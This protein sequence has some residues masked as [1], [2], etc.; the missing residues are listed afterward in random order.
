[1]DIQVMMDSFHLAWRNCSNNAEFKL[2]KSEHSMEEACAALCHFNHQIL[3]NGLHEW[4]EV[5]GA[6]EGPL[7]ISLIKRGEALKVPGFEVLVK[8]FGALLDTDFEKEMSRTDTEDCLNC[9]GKGEVANDLEDFDE[10]DAM[11]DCGECNGSGQIC[12]EPIM[13]LNEIECLDS[14]ESMIIPM[15]HSTDDSVGWIYAFMDRWD[16]VVDVLETEV[17]TKIETEKSPAKPL[18]KLVGSDGN[19]FAVIGVAARALRREG[20]RDQETEMRERVEKSQS[21]HQA[22][23]IIMEYVDPV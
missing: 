20:L 16:E 10:P 23:G 12:I 6:S 3:N 1:M 17:N 14:I 21:Y 2:W 11:F 19:I 13:R 9:N 8:S 15:I 7:F 22:L 18:C 4:F 5:Y